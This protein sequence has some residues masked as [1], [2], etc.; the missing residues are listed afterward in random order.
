VEEAVGVADVTPDPSVKRMGEPKNQPD[1]LVTA[2][3]F[4]PSLGRETDLQ[5]GF[6]YKYP[7]DKK[8]KAGVKQG[9]WRIYLHDDPSCKQHLYEAETLDVFPFERKQS[10]RQH[11]SGQKV[12]NRVVGE[13]RAVDS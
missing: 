9:G 6:A 12:P 7:T 1:Y 8:Q 10:K 13:I 3:V 11:P 4:D 2:A 5:I